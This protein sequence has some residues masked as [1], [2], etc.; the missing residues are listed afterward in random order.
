[1]SYVNST[2]FPGSSAPSG[3][4]AA[5]LTGVTAGH[6]LFAFLFFNATTT[7]GITSVTDSTG[8][9]WATSGSAIDCGGGTSIQCVNAT[10]A[11][12]SGTHTLTANYTGGGNYWGMVIEDTLTALRAAAV[13][14]QVANPLSGQTLTPG[15]TIGNA[16]DLVYMLALLAANS[17]AA[18]EPVAGTGG[19]TMQLPG[20]DVNI[21]AWALGYNASAGGTTPSFAPGSAGL[22]EPTGVLAMALKPAAVQTGPLPVG[23]PPRTQWHWR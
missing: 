17:T 16:G 9:T 1:M 11:V 19:F 14:R 3:S 7:P 15:A 22:G 10:S 21:G 13:G 23:G 2:N 8:T 5:S 20:F 6:G 12:G 4:S 18:G